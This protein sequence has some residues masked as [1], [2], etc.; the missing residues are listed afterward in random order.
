MQA[1]DLYAEIVMSNPHGADARGRYLEAAA[2]L[3][4]MIGTGARD[5]FHAWFEE[6]SAYF[7]GF[8]ADA[9]KLS[10]HIIDTMVAQP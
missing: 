6:V 9:M 5:E 1:P 10:D 3:N 8:A 2:R 4:R 7:R